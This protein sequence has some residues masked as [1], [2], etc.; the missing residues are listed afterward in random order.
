MRR[1]ITVLLYAVARSGDHFPGRASHHDRADRHFALCSSGLRLR[2]RAIHVNCTHGAK[3]GI[4]R[5][6]VKRER[7]ARTERLL[8]SCT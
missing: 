2:Q 4:C 6:D 8:H 5:H 1:R 3:V 7:C